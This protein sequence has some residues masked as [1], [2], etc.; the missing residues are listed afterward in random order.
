MQ[1]TRVMKPSVPFKDANRCKPNLLKFMA[2]F[3]SSDTLYTFT[4]LATGGDLFSMRL[5]YPDGLPEP[6]TKIII[7]QIVEAVSYLHDQDVAHRDLKP[8]K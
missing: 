2:A 3:R 7:R 8:E 4:E 1:V 5:R 6:N